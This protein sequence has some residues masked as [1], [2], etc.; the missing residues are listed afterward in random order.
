MYRSSRAALVD[1]AS[2]APVEQLPFEVKIGEVLSAISLASSDIFVLRGAARAMNWSVFIEAEAGRTV[3]VIYGDINL[4]LMRPARSR[5]TIA[6][7]TVVSS[8]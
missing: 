4:R 1:P 2:V 6:T 3:I 7:R 8:I 5:E